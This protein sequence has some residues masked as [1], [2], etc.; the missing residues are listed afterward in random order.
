MNVSYSKFYDL[1]TLHNINSYQVSKDTGIH[2]STLSDW[3]TGRSCPKADKLYVLASYF[4]VDIE[5]FLE[6]EKIG[7]KKE[8]VVTSNDIK[9]R[10]QTVK[11]RIPRDNDPRSSDTRTKT[12]VLHLHVNK[13]R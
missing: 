3:K 8:G 6:E 13:R 12:S 9:N 1:L 4:G 2:Q 7:R 11:D 5:Y 10:R